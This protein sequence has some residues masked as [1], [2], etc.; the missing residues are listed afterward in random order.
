[1]SQDLDDPKKA[2]LFCDG[3]SSG[4]PGDSGIGIMLTVGDQDVAISEYI[5]P[6]TNNIAEYRALIRG[7]QEARK[8]GVTIIDIYT[9]SEL[10]VKQIK[11]HYKVKSSNLVNLYEQAVSLLKDFKKFSIMHIPR[12]KNLKADVLAKHAIKRKLKKDY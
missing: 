3:A 4:N 2:T 6:S 1:M 9:D 7:I 11:G 10:M 8:F 5:G 12:E